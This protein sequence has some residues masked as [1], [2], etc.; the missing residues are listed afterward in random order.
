MLRDNQW[1]TDRGYLQHLDV[2]KR[3]STRKPFHQAPKAKPQEPLPDQTNS[4][5]RSVEPTLLR[6]K[7]GSPTF[8][9]QQI[10]WENYLLGKRIIETPPVI[11][12]RK[13]DEDYQR[14][15]RLVDCL[16]SSSSRKLVPC[17]FRVKSTPLII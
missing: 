7:E 8:R 14:H 2:L 15:R 1:S 5:Q 3:I 10:L 9:D 11:S 17:D 12:K 4:F 13:L 16:T 6:Q